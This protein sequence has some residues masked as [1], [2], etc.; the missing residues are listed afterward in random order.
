MNNLR[1]NELRQQHID[2]GKRIDELGILVEDPNAAF[3][4]A[5][6]HTKLELNRLESRE[7]TVATD[8]FRRRLAELLDRRHPQRVDPPAQASPSLR[9]LDEASTKTVLPHAWPD[10]GIGAAQC[11]CDGRQIRDTEPCPPPCNPDSW[12]PVLDEYDELRQGI[13]DLCKYLHGWA[14]HDRMA[15]VYAAHALEL[16]Q[17]ADDIRSMLGTAVES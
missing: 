8:G 9:E 6:I 11:E 12:E 13:D 16:V 14:D 5:Y 17:K 3:M 7:R 10:R 15:E 1:A 2:L 4:P